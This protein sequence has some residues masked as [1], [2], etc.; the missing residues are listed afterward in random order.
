[1]YKEQGGEIPLSAPFVTSAS[2]SRKGADRA[3][4][5]TLRKKK[6]RKK[7]IARAV[8]VRNVR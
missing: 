4:F 3:R 6:K 8:K 5:N 1:M 2:G 7:E